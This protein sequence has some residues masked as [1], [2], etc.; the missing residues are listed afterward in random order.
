MQDQYPHTQ[1]LVFS[2]EQTQNIE[3]ER[4]DGNSQKL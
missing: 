4:I 2:E 1:D 3:S